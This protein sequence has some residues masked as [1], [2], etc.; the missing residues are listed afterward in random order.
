KGALNSRATREKIRSFDKS[1][2]QIVSPGAEHVYGASR[3]AHGRSDRF[4]PL[5]L[6]IVHAYDGRIIRRHAG[7]R[8]FYGR[9]H[10]VFGE[11]SAGRGAGRSDQL[12][13]GHAGVIVT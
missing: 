11:Q 1:S 8:I 13:Q 3:A 9:S 6:E 2:Q 5:T 12:D 4:G 7:Q 10:F